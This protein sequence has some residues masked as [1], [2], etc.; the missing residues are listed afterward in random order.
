MSR[1][2]ARRERVGIGKV[3]VVEFQPVLRIDI[4]EQAIRAAVKAVAHQHVLVHAERAK[5]ER[6]NSSQKSLRLSPTQHGTCAQSALARQ[7]TVHA[8]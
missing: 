4:A 2:S 7:I 3:N 6:H 8:G 5:T 1:T